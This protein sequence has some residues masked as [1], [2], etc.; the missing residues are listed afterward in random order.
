M[1]DTLQIDVV[2]ESNVISIEQSPFLAC[3]RERTGIAFITPC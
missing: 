3:K 1:K 2:E